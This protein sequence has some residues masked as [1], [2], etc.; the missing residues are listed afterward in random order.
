MTCYVLQI[1]SALDH[2]KTAVRLDPSNAKYRHTLGKA[3]ESAEHWQQALG[4]YERAV[5]KDPFVTLYQMA[6]VKP[7]MRLRRLGRVVEVRVSVAVGSNP[8]WAL[9]QV[10][11]R[12]PWRYEPCLTFTAGYLEYVYLLKL[13]RC[14]T[15]L[16]MQVCRSVL[17]LEPAHP[18]AN[19]KCGGAL[20]QL[21]REPEALVHYR[22]HLSHFPDDEQAQFWISVL[23]GEA[24]AHAPAAHVA[25][26]FDYY[27]P[28]FEE[29]LVTSLQYCTPAALLDVLEQATEEPAARRKVARNGGNAAPQQ[30]WGC[31]VDLGCG[32][33]LMGPLLRER[34]TTLHGVDLSSKMIDKAREKACYDQL[35]VE[36]VVDFLAEQ[37]SRGQRYDLLVAADVLVY[38][39]DLEPLL[40]AAHVVGE[41]GSLFAFSTE[42]ATDEDNLAASSEDGDSTRVGYRCNATGRFRHDAAYVK[43]V[44]Q[45]QGWSELTHT[46][47]RIRCN[48]GAAVMGD[49]FVFAHD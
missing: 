31:C 23:S 46:Q 19:F 49:L 8:I 7:L 38:I 10:M 1:D 40:A 25:A 45:A 37:Q 47:A 26:L 6:Q 48:G 17:A 5:E 41:A 13:S 9:A 44:A 22:R 32:T 43:L 27:A 42:S 2:L 39:G 20:R 29:H 28:R 4:Q 35:F 11:Q 16:P 21:R 3:Y 18:R 14:T 34:V 33:G 15:S 30:D 24:V 36:D 12:N